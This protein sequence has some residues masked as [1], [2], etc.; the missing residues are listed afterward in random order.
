MKEKV[1]NGQI[2][3]TS[4]IENTKH[5]EKNEVSTGKIKKAR[6]SRSKATQRK[7]LKKDE[8]RSY[9]PLS[10]LPRKTLETVLP[11]AKVIY[12][13]FRGGSSPWDSIASM[14]KT[15]SKTNSFKYMIWSAEVYGIILKEGKDMYK[16]TEIARKIFTPTYPG[17]DKEAKIK[18]IMT[19][20]LLS[21]F[22]SEYD[23]HPIPKDEFFNNILSITFEVPK[24]RVEEAK[25]IILANAEY[26]GIIYTDSGANT[27]LL[28]LNVSNNDIAD[29]LNIKDS[30]TKRTIDSPNDVLTNDSNYETEF[31]KTCFIISPIGED[32]SE[33]RKHSDMILTHLIVPIAN[34][35][36]LKVVRADKIEKSGLITKQI[37]EHLV[38]SAYCI[39]D[40]S[41]SNPNVFYELGVR[42]MCQL[43]TIQIIRKGDKIPFDVSQGRTITIDLSDIYF[44]V[45]RIESAK[46]ELRDHFSSFQNKKHDEIAEDNPIKI[47]L[48]SLKI[49][50]SKN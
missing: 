2:T 47:Y 3:E 28:K 34:E 50:L 31:Q 6:R 9:I 10:V 35:F 24:E 40:L 41:F 25:E 17:E 12:E 38:N 15:S 39:A 30:A 36:G 29:K 16:I 49:S 1:L 43:P 13:N 22:Y 44:L 11:I 42:H 19:P 18:A 4:V 37:L 23:K 20:T 32:G 26:A 48:P 8:N 27:K 45:D 5:V 14:L 33:W 7:K 46:R 21:R